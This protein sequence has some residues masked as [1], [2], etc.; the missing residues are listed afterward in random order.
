ML[1]FWFLS[2]TYENVFAEFNV[3]YIWRR[4]HFSNIEAILQKYFR[5]IVIT[6]IALSQ[7]F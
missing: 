6:K 7:Q 2:K 5:H 1:Q 4:D 3:L